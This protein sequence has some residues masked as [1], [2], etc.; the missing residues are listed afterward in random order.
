MSWMTL[1]P[2]SGLRCAVAALALALVAVPAWADI[3][4]VKPGNVPNG[5]VAANSGA[6]W[7]LPTTLSVALGRTSCTE[8]WLAKGTYTGTGG[9]AFQITRN[10]QLYGGF[11]GTESALANR[12]SPLDASATVLDGED[13]RQVLVID[14]TT[15]ANSNAGS[16]TASTVIEGVTITRGR[17]FWG[18]GIQCKAMG[19]AQPALTQNRSCSPTIRQVRFVANRANSGGALF[20][21]A[22]TRGTASPT[23]TD[24]VFQGN[25][26]K[27]PA[28]AWGNGGA[29]YAWTNKAGPTNGTASP[30]ITNATLAA[31]HAA[32]GG[33]IYLTTGGSGGV[34]SPVIT[35]AT[36]AGNEAYAPAANPIAYGGAIYVDAQSGTSA[37]Q[38]NQTTFSG[39]RAVGT[40]RFGD[41]L[42][43]LGAQAKPVVRNSI[44][45]GNGQPN[46][47]RDID[48]SNGGAA[49]IDHSTVQSGCAAPH[50]CASVDTADA[51]LAP[52]ADNGGFGQ[53]LLPAATSPVL[54]KGAAAACPATDQRGQQRPAG[55]NCA[56]GAVERAAPSST[57]TLSHTGPGYLSTTTGP[58]CNTQATGACS[59]TAA[60]NTSVTVL[61]YPGPGAQVAGW[62]G[63]CLTATGTVCTFTLSGNMTASASFQA[64]TY[65][66]G[67]SV[68][69]LSG[70]GLVL[71]NNGGDDLAVAANGAFAFATRVASGGAYAVTVRSQPAGQVCSVQ[72][73]SGTASGNVGNV[74]VSCTSV[75]TVGGSVSG[76]TGT[77]LVLQNNGG[78]NLAVAAS[79]PF[80]FPA[81]LTAGGAYAVTIL[82]Q[83]AGQLCS[84]RGGSGSAS[85]N[86]TTVQVACTSTHQI[87]GTVTGLTGNLTLLNQGG[88]SLS[89]SSNG[90]FAFATRVLGGAAYAVTVGAQPA[91]QRCSIARGSGTATADVA[92]VAVQCAP[93][94]EGPIVSAGGAPGGTGSASFTGGGAGCRFD[95]AQTGFIAAPAQLPPGQTLPQGMFRFRVVGCDTGSTVT[96]SVNWPHPVTDYVKYGSLTVGAQP[97]YFAPD[98]LSFSGQSVSFRVTDGGRGDGDPADGVITDPTG[99]AVTAV[100]VPTLG[101]GM[102]AM[103]GALTAWVGGLRLR[104]RA[105]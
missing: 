87:G 11:E 58:A 20:L 42:F 88:D 16:I 31:N 24:V 38:L 13:M 50:T 98:A 71:R 105:T 96:M 7:A 81:P 52:L 36:F 84:V 47:V 83:P 75:Y 21:D 103:L 102:L 29:I 12:A 62:G 14:G 27:T 91:G 97:S 63:A 40:N 76:Y 56:Q 92:D 54:G 25:E 41:A 8:I 22:Q 17:A 69:G 66:V 68:S 19:G 67:G 48:V 9:A 2:R 34:A 65:A 37:L 3:C 1:S 32:M 64:I 60:A 59:V 99:P 104:R 53:T 74:Q 44:F 57:L 15:G 89:V 30:I 93:F 49:A 6:D 73:G 26:A 82:S 33:A 85:A 51:Q 90:P 101:V 18:G 77:G 86:V 80:T 4:R 72:N 70:A 94:F 95:M 79:G 46:A 55:Q 43:L 61:A 78:D 5:G 10:L 23:L 35:N 100:A 45:W 28:G 39:N